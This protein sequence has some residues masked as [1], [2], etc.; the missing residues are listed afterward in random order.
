MRATIQQYFEIC[1]PEISLAVDIIKE[2]YKSRQVSSKGLSAYIPGGAKA[3][4]KVRQVERFYSKNYVERTFF[5]T[6]SKAYLALVNLF[7]Q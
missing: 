4:S 1:T 7:C 5:L 3:D 6:Q 2:I